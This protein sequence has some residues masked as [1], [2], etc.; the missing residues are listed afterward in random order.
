MNIYVKHCNV[1]KKL[2]IIILKPR[3]NHGHII[4]ELDCQLRQKK[5][6]EAFDLHVR[7]HLTLFCIKSNGVFYFFKIYKYGEFLQFTRMHTNSSFF[8][9]G[10]KSSLKFMFYL[11][12]KIDY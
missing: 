12:G 5:K 1:G 9:G 11:S 8:W 4:I 10:K 2:K 3:A 7:R 6:S